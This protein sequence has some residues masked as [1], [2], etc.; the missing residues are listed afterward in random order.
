MLVFSCKVGVPLDLGSSVPKGLLPSTCR[1]AGCYFSLDV[2]LSSVVFGCYEAIWMCQ[3]AHACLPSLLSCRDQVTPANCSLCKPSS[4]LQVALEMQMFT[5]DGLNGLCHAHPRSL[6]FQ[7]TQQHALI[8]KSS[9]PLALWKE[10]GSWSS[11]S[12]CPK[13]ETSK[14]GRFCWRPDILYCRKKLEA[15]LFSQFVI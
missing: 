15:T 7:V 8:F 6:S 13:E 2:A 1:N 5:C 12:S 9:G 4:V 14:S 11:F 3:L 10:P